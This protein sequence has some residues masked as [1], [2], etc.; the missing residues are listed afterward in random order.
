MCKMGSYK[1]WSVVAYFSRHLIFWYWSNYS[2]FKKFRY[3]SKSDAGIVNAAYY[4]ADKRS[5]Y[6]DKPA[7]N[8][9]WTQS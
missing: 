2:T 7:G 4:M 8:F 1:N 6:F 3:S 5:E 9:I